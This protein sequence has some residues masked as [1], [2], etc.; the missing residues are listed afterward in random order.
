TIAH[1]APSQCST[2]VSLRVSVCDEPTAKQSVLLAHAA[3]ASPLS[4]ASATFGLGTIAHF[5]PSHRSISVCCPPMGPVS[6][7]YEPTAKQFVVLEHASPDNTLTDA[8]GFGV[9]SSDHRLALHRSASVF[10]TVDVLY[11]PTAMQNELLE[12]FT[13][14]RLLERVP[15]GVGLSCA[16]HFVPFQRS[17]SFTPVPEESC[18]PTA[19]QALGAGHE[20]AAR[21]PYAAP[22]AVGTTVHLGAAAEAEGAPT[23]T[24]MT[25]AASA[26]AAPRF[27]VRAP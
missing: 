25:A 16:T 12:H 6:T 1:T 27:T 21:C 4:N 18:V 5:L 15:H 24:N 19:T 11:C 22:A 2:S 20:T 8:F 10:V 26:P 17:M 9:G 23:A 14:A 7:K 13:A 3:P